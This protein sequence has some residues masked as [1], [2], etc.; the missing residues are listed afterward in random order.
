MLKSMKLGRFLALFTLFLHSLSAK[1]RHF[2]P[3]SLSICSIALDFSS[4]E[5]GF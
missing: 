3:F 4:S 1:Y 2:A 5:N